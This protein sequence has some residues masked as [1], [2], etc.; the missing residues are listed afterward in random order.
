MYE[1]SAGCILAA[2]VLLSDVPRSCAELVPHQDIPQP[3]PVWLWMDYE[4]NPHY[5]TG[6][7]AYMQLNLQ[8][9]SKNAPGPDFIVHK[10]NHNNIMDFIPDLPQ[11][12]SRLPYAAATS[13]LVRTAVLY[14]HGGVYLD[15]DFLV[16][17]PLNEYVTHLQHND[18]VAYE[19]HGQNCTLGQFSSNFIAARKHNALYE[20]SWMHIKNELQNR[21]KKRSNDAPDEGICCY[22]AQGRPREC[23]IPWAG[24]GERTS[25]SKAET[26]LKSGR[27]KLHCYPYTRGFVPD[28]QNSDETP[29]ALRLHSGSVAWTR[30]TDCD[31]GNPC[32]CR[33][34]QDDLRCVWGSNRSTTTTV[35]RYFGRMAYHLFAST[36]TAEEKD[37]SASELLNGPYAL[38]ELYRQALNAIGDEPAMGEQVKSASPRHFEG[39]SQKLSRE[40]QLGKKK[41]IV[42]AKERWVLQQAVQNSEVAKYDEQQVS[43][44]PD[45]SV[46]ARQGRKGKKGVQ[47]PD[48]PFYEQ[49]HHR[50]LESFLHPDSAHRDAGHPLVLKGIVFGLAACGTLAIL[51]AFGTLDPRRRRACCG[52][53]CPQRQPPK[54]Y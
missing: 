32:P 37:I 14:H 11:E 43:R 4:D 52:L 31:G 39:K 40:K 22:D 35:Q 2:G 6:L 25:H 1:I 24:L 13:D 34:V 54:S 17:R 42:G 7:P 53:S 50:A 18:F 27:L 30:I 16:V 26:L 48:H 10:L 20:E 19:A 36:L 49:L 8:S 46:L 29:E 33:R 21:C 51:L 3:F 23:H 9:L 5:K 44:L 28:I 45:G 38:S 41:K 12:F 15:T 47:L